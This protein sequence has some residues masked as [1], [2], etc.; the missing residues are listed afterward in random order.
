MCKTFQR[1]IKVIYTSI[2]LL[3]AIQLGAAQEGRVEM[4]PRKWDEK[5]TAKIQ[6]VCNP[7]E[8]IIE[9]GVFFER[10][11]GQ[12]ESSGQCRLEETE[13]K[14]RSE[15]ETSQKEDQNWQVWYVLIIVRPKFQFEAFP[16][17]PSTFTW[18]TGFL[19]GS[20]LKES[21]SACSLRK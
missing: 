15:V 5:H 3:H 12:G 11:I 10:D 8:K 20:R 7:N 1:M 13:E 4:V 16:D 9:T 6:T 21:K 17:A 18:T 14:M 19:D 2:F